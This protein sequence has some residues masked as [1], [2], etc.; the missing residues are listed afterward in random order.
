MAGGVWLRVARDAYVLY[1]NSDEY[2]TGSFE[3]YLR[4]YLSNIGVLDLDGC[5][6][7]SKSAARNANQTFILEE[8]AEM[9]ARLV[10]LAIDNKLKFGSAALAGFVQGPVVQVQVDEFDDDDNVGFVE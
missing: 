6:G 4:R 7:T 10:Q 1:V 2:G 3:S 5:K 8:R 9:R